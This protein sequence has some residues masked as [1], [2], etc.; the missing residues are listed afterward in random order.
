MI[1][2]KSLHRF[3]PLALA[4]ASALALAGCGGSHHH[5]TPGETSNGSGV[6]GSQFELRALSVLRTQLTAAMALPGAGWSVQ[7]HTSPAAVLLS[8]PSPAKGCPAATLQASLNASLLLAA[9]PPAAAFAQTPLAH[10]KTN[11][12]AATATL[13]SAS[14]AEILDIY[15]P[16]RGRTTVLRLTLSA[17]ANPTCQQLD[18]FDQVAASRMLGTLALTLTPTGGAKVAPPA[19][20]RPKGAAKGETH[21]VGGRGQAQAPAAPEATLGGASNATTIPASSPPSPTP[22]PATPGLERSTFAQWVERICTASHLA[23]QGA[24]RPVSG[25]AAAQLRLKAL[26]YEY[27]SLSGAE[28]YAPASELQ[29]FAAGVSQEAQAAALLSAPKPTAQDS[30]QATALLTG[31][32]RSFAALGV[33][34]CQ[35]P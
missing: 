18:A 28:Q 25:P 3:A 24:G 9:M 13:S 21:T 22:A 17:P 32:R 19:L 4:L 5:K 20:V 31:A 14:G 7:A 10:V 15:I 16:D 1:T 2:M 35:A 33:S 23:S 11:E 8:G 26:S 30:S 12:G 27:N 6:Q 29:A 34:A